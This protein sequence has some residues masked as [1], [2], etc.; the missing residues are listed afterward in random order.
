VQSLRKFVV[1]GRG[2]KLFL[3]LHKYLDISE[4]FSFGNISQKEM[5]NKLKDNLQFVRAHEMK[6]P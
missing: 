6:K 5:G 3:T 2:S 1:L 4:D